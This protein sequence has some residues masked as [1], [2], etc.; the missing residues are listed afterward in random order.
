M[1]RRTVGDLRAD[2]EIIADDVRAQITSGELVLGEALP[3][4]VALA[5]EYGTAPATAQKAVD[6]LKGEGY[7]AATRGRGTYVISREPAASAG[8]E[9]IEMLKAVLDMQEELEAVLRK[10][11]RRVGFGG[12]PSPRS[13][14]TRA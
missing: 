8:D 13:G 11:K 3:A 12:A 1:I 2:Y 6:V 5:R 9:R 4:R 7:V 14:P 10:F